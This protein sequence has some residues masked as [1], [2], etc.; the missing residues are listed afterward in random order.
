MKHILL[1]LGIIISN[2][3]FSQ[4][5]SEVVDV[6]NNERFENNEDKDAQNYIAGYLTDFFDKTYEKPNGLYL[7]IEQRNPSNRNTLEIEN[8]PFLTSTDIKI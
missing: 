6:G 7:V 5:T 8:V 3:F 4:N 2:S 1:I